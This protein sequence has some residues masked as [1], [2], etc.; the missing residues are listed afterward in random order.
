[1]KTYTAR[2]EW[3]GWLGFS[4]TMAGYLVVAFNAPW[5]VTAIAVLMSLRLERSGDERGASDG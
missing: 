3:V 4:L 1:M 2:R 5:F